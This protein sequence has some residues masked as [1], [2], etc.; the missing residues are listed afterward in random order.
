MQILTTNHLKILNFKISSYTETHKVLSAESQSKL[1]NIYIYCLG[2]GG[3][4]NENTIL[5]LRHFYRNSL[6]ESQN[7]YF[8]QKCITSSHCNSNF[9]NYSIQLFNYSKYKKKKNLNWEKKKYFWI[10]V[11][12]AF[13]MNMKKKYKEIFLS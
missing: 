5:V 6:C 13:F 11:I 4:E 9:L 1:L 8:A 10:S 2:S 3:I 7:D 12:W